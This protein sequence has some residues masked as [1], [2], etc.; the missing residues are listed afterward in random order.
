MM[1]SFIQSNYLGFGSGIVIPDTGIAMQ[2]RGYGFMLDKSH[3]NCVAGGKRP[4]Q[5]IIPGFVTRDNRSLMS[6][7]VMGGQYQAAGHAN[8]ISNLVDFGMDPQTALDSKH[9]ARANVVSIDSRLEFDPDEDD[10]QQH[11][12][13]PGTACVEPPEVFELL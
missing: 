1:I 8:L 12:C 6:F 4:F 13:E 2:N 3:P 10:Q 9:A 7:G 11:E 5:T